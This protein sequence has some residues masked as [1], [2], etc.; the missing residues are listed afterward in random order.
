[1]PSVTVVSAELIKR[2]L[3]GW[4]PPNADRPVIAAESDQKVIA[5]WPPPELQRLT[6]RNFVKFSARS[7]N[8]C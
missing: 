5:G 4:P 3:S 2:M 1:M 6:E 8:I 7:R